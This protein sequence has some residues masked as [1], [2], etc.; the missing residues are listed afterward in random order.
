MTAHPPLKL[1]LCEGKDD[2]LVMQAL[3]DHG[4][5][6]SDLTFED[7]GNVGTLRAYLRAL[8]VR[9]DF[10]S[11]QIRSVFLTRDADGD[12]AGAWQSVRDAMTDVF[13]LDLGEPSEWVENP[14]G[15]RFAG[16]VVPGERQPGMIET[17]CLEAARSADPASFECLD[18]FI[19]CLTDAQ[20]TAPHE[21]ARFHIWTILAQKPGAQDRLSLERALKAV[22]PDWDAPAFGTLVSALAA[23]AS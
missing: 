14:D 19:E 21:K 6:G 11:G 18:P 15:I 4:G 9:P 20:G 23:A 10:V 3:A 2:R 12:P 13:A 7:Y 16:W 1:V 8:R 22:P 5:F 17:L